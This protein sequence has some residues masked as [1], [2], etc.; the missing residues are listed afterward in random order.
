[1]PSLGIPPTSLRLPHLFP[2]S[3]IFQGSPA[4]VFSPHLMSHRTFCHF[5]AH[6][7]SLSQPQTKIEVLCHEQGEGN[8]NPFR[9]SCLDNPLDR[10]TRRAIVHGFTKESETTEWLSNKNSTNSK[11]VLL[12]HSRTIYVSFFTSNLQHFFLLFLIPNSQKR[13]AVLWLQMSMLYREN[14]CDL[15]RTP[16]CPA[17]DPSSTCVGN[18][19]LHHPSILALT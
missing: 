10:W 3:L 1:M 4:S 5:R 13:R 17:P 19:T 16:Q 9:Y 15:M 14:R 12:F 2:P 11:A 7:C 18:H 8:G 6:Y